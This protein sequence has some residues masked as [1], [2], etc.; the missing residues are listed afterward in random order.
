MKECA[1]NKFLFIENP[2]ITKL[3]TV[4]IEKICWG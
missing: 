3:S 2:M 4:A 1:R